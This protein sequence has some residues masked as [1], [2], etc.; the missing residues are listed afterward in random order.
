VNEVV[1][2]F[3]K[4]MSCNGQ[5]PIDAKTLAEHSVLILRDVPRMLEEIKGARALAPTVEVSHGTEDPR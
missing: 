3:R 4:M 2:D 1:N 5:L